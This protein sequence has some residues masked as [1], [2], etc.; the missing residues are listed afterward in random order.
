MCASWSWG[1]RAL[2]VAVV[3]CLPASAAAQGPNAASAKGRE[4]FEHVWQANDPLASG[5]GLGPMYNGSSCAACHY[6]GGLGGAGAAQQNVQ[7]L[8]ALPPKRSTAS[9]RSK[10]EAL[11]PLFFG[12]LGTTASVMLHR[13]S[14]TPDYADWRGKFGQDAGRA[15][16]KPVRRVRAGGLTFSLAER[17]SP[18]LFGAGLIDRVPA[19][20]LQEAAAEQ[21]R[22]TTET[23]GRVPRAAFGVGRFGWRG[24]TGTLREFV[25][26]ACAVELGLE[27]P[28]HSQ[29]RDPLEPTYRPP[30]FDLTAAQVDDLTAFVASLPA[31]REVLPDDADRR[32][33]AIAGKETFVTV[34]CA[35][36]HRENLGAVRGLYSDL[37]LHDLGASL[38]GPV[39][40][41]ADTPG[42]T[43]VRFGGDFPA[44]FGRDFPAQFADFARP[45]E[46]NF[47]AGQ[48]NPA[49]FFN[50]YLGAVNE[51][52]ATPGG[53][54]EWRTPPLWGVADSAP[55]LHDGRAPD[56]KTAVLL[57]DGQARNARKRF[58]KMPA[59]EQ[60]ALLE[61]LRT[62]RAP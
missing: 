58:E 59:S 55:Y 8:T 1:A 38:E 4:L 42:F 47:R 54:R 5:D 51:L 7:L 10:L 56:L 28:G 50:S 34:G 32:A 6:Q 29:E 53:T 44:R 18:A 62:L 43:F 57:H 61:F 23:A 9:F 16:A 52:F 33:A 41:N 25:G 15:S 19:E 27:V 24:Q 60:A 14:T 37:L 46:Q 20:V 49:S 35:A 17:T 12:G 21:R 2:W 45:M 39:P 40:P 3:L 22:R 11:H 31:P 36:C 26:M 30:G 13:Q 48:F